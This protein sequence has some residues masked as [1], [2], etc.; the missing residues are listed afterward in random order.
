MEHEI[1]SQWV[2]KTECEHLLRRTLIFF[3]NIAHSSST[4]W[5]QKCMLEGIAGDLFGI[6]KEEIREFCAQANGMVSST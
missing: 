5:D 2:D 6:S 1:L 4:L 3:D